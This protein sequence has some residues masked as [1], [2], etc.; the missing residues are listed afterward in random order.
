[1]RGDVAVIAR[2]FIPVATVNYANG[3]HGH[4]R[5]K[6]RRRKAQRAVAGMVLAAH[7]WPADFRMPTVE[8]PCR[9]VL[10]RVTTYAPRMDDD[11]LA[12]SLKSVRDAVAAHLG[13]DDKHRHVVRYCYEQAKGEAMGVLVTLE[14]AA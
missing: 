11:G 9:V 1:L 6:S 5:T 13:V 10:T 7:P 14:G 4:W 12:S 3:S 2:V 8:R